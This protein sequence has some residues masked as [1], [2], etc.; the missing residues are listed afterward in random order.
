MAYS[1]ATNGEVFIFFQN[2][3][4]SGQIIS[5]FCNIFKKFYPDCVEK[6]SPVNSSHSSEEHRAFF[7][8]MLLRAAAKRMPAHAWWST[9]GGSIQ[10]LQNV[11]VKVLAHVSTGF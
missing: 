3:T 11:A 10:E 5:G 9:F 4:K 8:N 2:V 1:Q 7:A 6:Q